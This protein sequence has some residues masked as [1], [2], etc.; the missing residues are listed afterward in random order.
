MPLACLASDA[1]RSSARAACSSASFHRY[2]TLHELVLAKCYRLMRAVLNTAVEEDKIL[3]RNPCKVRGADKEESPE[4]PVLTVAK[5]L[6]GHDDMRAAIIY[7][8]ASSEADQ[9]IATGSL[10]VSTR[11][12]EKDA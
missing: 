5:D 10:S 1:I 12:G 11:T 9:A 4:R 3:S 8:H 6:M 7:Q 2:F